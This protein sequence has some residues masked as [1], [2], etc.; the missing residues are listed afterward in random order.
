MPSH[1]L[2]VLTRLSIQVPA[3]LATRAE[4]WHEGT[5][6]AE[7]LLSA[8]VILL[9]DG[10]EGLETYLLHRHARMPFAASMVVFPGGRVDPTD[11]AAGTGSDPVRLCALRKTHEETG[12]QLTEEELMPWAHWT[13]PELE[14][15]RYETYFFIAVLPTDQ[16]AQ[17]VSTETDRAA[18]ATPGAALAEFARGEIALM[19]PTLSMLLELADVADAD[20]IRE[21][22]RDRIVAPV[23]PR[24]S[25]TDEGWTFRYP[26]HR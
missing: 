20:E 5:V 7:P 16:Q 23:L 2:D 9:R 13:T 14:P 22:A 21:V 25:R 1:S 3:A 11:A 17:D 12:V 19:P 8:S 26:V 18:W 10:P 15:R 6:P 24:L 4:A